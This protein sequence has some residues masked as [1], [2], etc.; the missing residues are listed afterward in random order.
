[1]YGRV[2]G[3]SYAELST[4][5]LDRKTTLCRQVGQIID[6][7]HPGMTRS[8]ALLMYETHLPLVLAARARLRAGVIDINAFKRVLLE[9]VT[10]LEFCK[11]VLNWEDSA[12]AEAAVSRS[13]EIS[14]K[15]LRSEQ[16]EYGVLCP[17]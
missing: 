15:Q 7:V 17:V 3:Y 2:A 13:V 8:R 10:M 5:L 6:V 4:E 14:L 9:A 1:M 16:I 12:S 11:S